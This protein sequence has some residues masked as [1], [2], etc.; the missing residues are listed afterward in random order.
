VPVPI[1]P[2][3]VGPRGVREVDPCQDVHW[4]VRARGVQPAVHHGDHRPVSGDGVPGNLHPD[5]LEVPL[6]FQ[7]PS[8]VRPP[9]LMASQVGLHVVVVRAPA[10]L[11]D[12]LQ[13]IPRGRDLVHRYVDLGPL[14]DR[15]QRGPPKGNRLVRR[16]PQADQETLR[17]VVAWLQ[18]VQVR[19]GRDR[20]HERPRAA[21]AGCA[22]GQGQR[23]PRQPE[24]EARRCGG[25]WRSAAVGGHSGQPSP[26]ST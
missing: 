4:G 9:E 16:R 13:H 26:H 6:V 15:L 2:V 25:P 3:R 23:R 19:I 21:F 11:A 5:V 12:D 1:D 14:P 7:I 24:K 18:R 8:V 17:M 10:Q 20:I 22:G